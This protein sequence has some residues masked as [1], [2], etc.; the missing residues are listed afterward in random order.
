[1]THDWAKLPWSDPRAQAGA[2]RRMLACLLEANER[3]REAGI[4][5]QADLDAFCRVLL[6]RLDV[7]EEVQARALALLGDLSADDSGN[8]S[9]TMR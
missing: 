2:H 9:V 4:I 8:D 6:A 7:P 3:L 1:M 5:D